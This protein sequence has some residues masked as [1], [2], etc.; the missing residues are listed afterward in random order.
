MTAEGSGIGFGTARGRWVLVATV[1]G[2]ALAF[3]DATVVNVALPRIG[4]E[5]GASA[6]GLQWTVNGY[7]LTLASFILLGGALGDR[8]GRR[9]VFVV[10]VA[11]FALA[12]AACGLAWSVE[13]LVAA[14]ALQGLA[15]ALL[16][17]GSLAL[18][19]ASFRP[20]DR[21]RAIGAWSGLG[22]VAGAIG[23]FL[24]GWLV[25]VASWRLV[26]LVN[27]PVAAAVVAVALRAVPESRD[28]S[29]A[30]R[31]DVAGA[32]SAAVGLAG[33]TAGLTA[34]ADRGPG[35]AAVAGA[36][37]LGVAGLVA[38]VAVERQSPHPML[39]LALFRARAFAGA[40][41]VTFAVYAALGGVFFLLVLHLQVVAGFTPLRAGTALL[42]VTVI[43]LLFSARAG[44][45]AERIGPRGPMT[46]GP[47]VCAGAL[48]LLARVAGGASYA[49]D[50]LPG[51]L[52][53]GAGLALTVAPLTSTALASAE[54]RFAGVAS[55]VNNAVARAAGLLAVA[56][57]PLA[58]GMSGSLTEP[59]VLGARFGVAMGICAG[60]LTA[61]AGLAWATIPAKPVRA[62][63]E[64][65][66]ERPVASRRAATSPV[67]VHCA[68]AGPPLHPRSAPEG[69]GSAGALGGR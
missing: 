69:S 33:L 48:L 12:S 25:E 43:M 34:W 30:P 22:G 11:G 4:A 31:L 9:R 57:L 7:T 67:R 1:L 27:V 20:E 52:L 50:V 2:S 24:G 32:A 10:G 59:A 45:L 36:L 58:A 54:A 38:F 29:A 28:A 17:P 68:V 65:G 40:N 62:G 5:L 63:A 21:G 19:E 26:F 18:L 23:P 15:G 53:L 35:S 60:L 37:A 6:A 47:L 39:P 3:I 64:R 49:R 46:V 61:G 44:A 41:L 55:G 16:T 13:S 14:R 51:V 42:P 66:P 56:G 8:H